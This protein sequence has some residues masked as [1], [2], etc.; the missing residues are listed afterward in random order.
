M[1]SQEIQQLTRAGLQ[2][3]RLA[4]TASLISPTDPSDF[5]TPLTIRHIGVT[6]VKIW[7]LMEFIWWVKWSLPQDLDGWLIMRLTGA[8]EGGDS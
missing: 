6:G 2:L 4:T 7:R 3:T 5:F 1:E 8:E